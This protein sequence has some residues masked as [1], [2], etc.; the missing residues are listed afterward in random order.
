MIVG[1]AIDTG[2]SAS[3]AQE[4]LEYVSTEFIMSEGGLSGG[5]WHPTLILSTMYPQGEYGN[6]NLRGA[7]IIKAKVTF[8]SV[9]YAPLGGV[10]V[11]VPAV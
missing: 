9:R 4:V 5:Q 8:R 3:T 10:N 11:V 2:I 6:P 1:K 7:M